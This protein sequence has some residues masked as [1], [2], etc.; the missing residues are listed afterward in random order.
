MSA[1]AAPTLFNE[2][3]EGSQRLGPTALSTAGQPIR[4][5][6]GLNRHPVLAALQ[7]EIRLA[8]YRCGYLRD[9]E[10]GNNLNQGGVAF[11]LNGAVALFPP[12]GSG[13]CL[14]LAGPGSVVNVE[15]LTDGPDR[16][17]KV[18]VRGSALILQAPSLWEI[19]GR[20][21]ASR[22][23]IEQLL[24]QQAALEREVVCNA[25][26]PAGQ[27]LARWLMMLDEA[28]GGGQ[29]HI[30]QAALADMLG[31]QRTSV[32]AAARTLQDCGALRFVRGRVRILNRA[33]V[34]ARACACLGVAAGRMDDPGP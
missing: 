17:R 10:V 1:A 22:L 18:L 27:R 24:V 33:A 9:V 12:D 26:H 31:V 15:A 16:E 29:I 13:I 8:I 20:D 3:S 32:N 23:M 6:P 28:A 4:P 14:G 21:R 2:E 11:M 5:E 30:T 25:R 7:P 34:Q 19:L